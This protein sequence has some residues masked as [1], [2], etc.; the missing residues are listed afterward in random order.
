MPSAW[1]PLT[2]ASSWSLPCALG[3]AGAEDS[4]VQPAHP[5]AGEGYGAIPGPS[6][7]RTVVYP[8]FFLFLKQM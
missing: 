1:W 2:W 7:L 6:H 4:P 8:S 5:G 3:S